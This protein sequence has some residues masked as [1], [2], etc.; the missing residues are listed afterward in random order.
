MRIEQ[1]VERE[2]ERI[3]HCTKILKL[4]L[5][6]NDRKLWESSIQQYEKSMYALSILKELE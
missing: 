3:D 4:A 6:E 2:E 1:A 5:N